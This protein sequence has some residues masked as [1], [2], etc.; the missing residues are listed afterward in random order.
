[1]VALLAAACT[2]SDNGDLP[3]GGYDTWT[4]DEYDQFR[5]VAIAVLRVKAPDFGLRMKVRR[6][7]YDGILGRNYSPIKPQTVDA[8]MEG[9]SFKPHDVDWDATLKVQITKWKAL[10]GS[11]NHFSADAIGRL[12]H[13][14]GE[15]L[16]KCSFYDIPFTVRVHAGQTDFSGAA[17]A[18]AGYFVKRLPPRPPLSG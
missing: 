13:K 4:H 11:P 7:L 16:W 14:S 10:R 8:S 6:H 18:I 2:N 3:Q 15:L 9:E 1:M 12:T 17:R 5:P